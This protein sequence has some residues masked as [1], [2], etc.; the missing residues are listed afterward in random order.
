[1]QKRYIEREYRG[2][3]VGMPS[4]PAGTIRGAIGRDLRNRLE[5]AIRAEG[6]P[7]VTHYALREPL[8]DAAELTFRLETGRTHQIRVH[9]AALGLPDLQR[10]DLRPARSALAAPR[11]KRCTR[12]GSR[13]SIR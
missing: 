2:I 4:E 7:A 10:S 5:Y 9:L 11:A 6:K 1:M 12:G 3:V 13:S 8:R